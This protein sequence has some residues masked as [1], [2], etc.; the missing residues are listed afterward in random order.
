MKKVK[1]GDRRW[2]VSNSGKTWKSSLPEE[3]AIWLFR[4]LTG[5]RPDEFELRI[6]AELFKE[7]R[8]MFEGEQERAERLVSVG[9]SKRDKGL[10]VKEL[11]AMTAVAQAVMNSDATVWK[12]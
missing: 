7:Q 8:R 4:Q 1:E 12:R 10:D 3:E 11:A 9:A 2:E 6:L 5:R